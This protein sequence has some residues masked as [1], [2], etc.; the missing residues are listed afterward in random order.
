VDDPPEKKRFAS[1]RV[2]DAA[3]LMTWSIGSRCPANTIKRTV[4][5]RHDARWSEVP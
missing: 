4:R 3:D 2:F 5:T 1:L